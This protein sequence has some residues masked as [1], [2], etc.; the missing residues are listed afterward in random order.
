MKIK[1]LNKSQLGQIIPDYKRCDHYFL[2]NSYNICLE[3]HP[4]V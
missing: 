4:Q 1:Y 2:P 3:L